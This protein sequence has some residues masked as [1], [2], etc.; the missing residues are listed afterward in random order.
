MKNYM[1]RKRRNKWWKRFRKR[2]QDL[3]AIWG[4]NAHRGLYIL[5]RRMTES[6][7]KS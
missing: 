1:T 2:T 6:E 3:C 4:H 7:K 5:M